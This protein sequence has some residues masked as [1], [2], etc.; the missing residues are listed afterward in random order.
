MSKEDQRKKNEAVG[1]VRQVS[2]FLD[3]IHEQKLKLSSWF[4]ANG[5]WGVK[6]HLIENDPSNNDDITDVISKVT[7]HETKFVV[8]SDIAVYSEDCI[9]LCNLNA[10]SQTQSFSILTINLTPAT[11]EAYVLFTW[12]LQAIQAEGRRKQ[13]RKLVQRLLEH[14]NESDDH[15]NNRHCSLCQKEL[16]GA[17][18]EH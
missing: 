6:V 12:E 15:I 8:A 7:T 16:V 13:R 10:W 11:P 3:T 4:K 17:T 14:V 1:L 9:E 2:P 5:F 18:R